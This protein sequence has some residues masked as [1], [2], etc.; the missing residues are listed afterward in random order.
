MKCANCG[1]NLEPGTRFCGGCGAV[2][3]EPYADSSSAYSPYGRGPSP[4]SSPY[5]GS[6]PPA[7]PDPPM[8]KASRRS[9]GGGFL[10]PTVNAAQA[11]THQ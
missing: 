2:V 7:P 4:D 8:I 5:A 6:E 3:A 9:G 10:R 1:A 11:N